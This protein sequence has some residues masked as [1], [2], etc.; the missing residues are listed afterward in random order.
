MQLPLWIIH[1]PAL[2]CR[3]IHIFDLPVMLVDPHFRSVFAN[4]TAFAPCS[5]VGSFD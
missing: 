1:Y 5:S 4:S 2:T 3:I